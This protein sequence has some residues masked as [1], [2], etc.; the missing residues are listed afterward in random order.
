M[1]CLKFEFPRNQRGRL[2]F[3]K[4]GSNQLE[5]IYTDK[6]CDVLL[7]N[8]VYLDMNNKTPMNGI[9]IKEDTECTMSIQYEITP[10]S[11]D[12]MVSGIIHDYSNE[13][14]VNFT[15]VN[16]DFHLQALIGQQNNDDTEIAHENADDILCNFLESLGYD[17][18]VE[19]YKKIRKWYA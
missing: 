19:E 16:E 12:F 15:R 17:K 1:K 9:W 6:N 2:Y 4:S 10:H 3:F 5:L 8:P 14:N 11:N 7:P 18:I 13:F